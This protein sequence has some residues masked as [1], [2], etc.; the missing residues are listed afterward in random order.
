LRLRKS[1]RG[2]LVACGAGAPPRCAGAPKPTTHPLRLPLARATSR[3]LRRGRFPPPPPKPT[4]TPPS[5]GDSRLCLRLRKSH[6]GL[7]VACGAGAPPPPPGF[8]LGPRSRTTPG[9]PP[10]DPHHI[11]SATPGRVAPAR[12]TMGPL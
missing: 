9:Q 12:R 3:A 1:H 7:L 2:L 5:G 4:N 8:V 11:N 6:R 10:G